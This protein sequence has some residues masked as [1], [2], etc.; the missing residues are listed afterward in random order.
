[1]TFGKPFSIEGLR[2]TEEALRQ[3]PELTR[4]NVARRVLKK[5]AEPIAEAGARNAHELTGNLR[6]SY[7]IGTRL[8][9]RQRA[10]HRKEPDTVEVFVGPTDVAG[11]QEEFG[12]DHQIAHPHL[13][14]AWDAEKRNALDIVV[15]SLG[16]EIGKAV[17]RMERKAARLAAQ[18]N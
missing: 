9:K 3:L 15:K 8:N 12:N 1:M 16:D 18:T 13:R 11:V 5:G 14:P 6:E 17:K 10:L 7:G 4:A 2:Q